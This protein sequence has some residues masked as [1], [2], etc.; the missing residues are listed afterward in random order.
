MTV[1]VIARRND[2]AIHLS[3]FMDCRVAP[4]SFAPR[5][6]GCRSPRLPMTKKTGTAIAIPVFLLTSVFRT[7]VFL[8]HHN[9]LGLD[10]VAVDE[11]EHIDSGGGVDLGGGVAV[12]GLGA[13]HAAGHIDN[14]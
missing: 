1:L 9:L 11:A 12:D 8:L 3:C 10:V 14:L 2:E 7:S 6:D 5:N 4:H 13:E